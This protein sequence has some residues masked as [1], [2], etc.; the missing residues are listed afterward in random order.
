MPDRFMVLVQSFPYFE[1]FL[2][3]EGTYILYQMYHRLAEYDCVLLKLIL[4]AAVGAPGFCLKLSVYLISPR[5]Y[6]K[7]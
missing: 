1:I 5:P 7:E 3:V 4:R 6:K 2:L